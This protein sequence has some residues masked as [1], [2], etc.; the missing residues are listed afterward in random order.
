[1]NKPSLEEL[2]NVFGSKTYSRGFNYYKNG[3]VCLGVKKDDKLWGKVYGTGSAPYKV[4][5]DVSDKIY[6]RCSC[7][8]PSYFN[9][10]S[11]F[12]KYFNFP[13]HSHSSVKS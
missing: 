2:K 6:S 1:M 10:K 12:S 8:G 5:V 13:P 11:I 4:Q 3:H 7:P 9:K